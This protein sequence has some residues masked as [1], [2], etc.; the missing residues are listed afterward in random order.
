MSKMKSRRFW[1]WMV[2]TIIVA[3]SIVITKTLSPELISWY[4]AISC[5]YI[6][7]SVA[8]SYIFKDKV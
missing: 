4:G 2:W 8:K 1:V 7:S 6:G 3:A 5:L